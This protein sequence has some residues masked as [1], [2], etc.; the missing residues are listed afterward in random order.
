MQRL[1][2]HRVVIGVGAE[3]V[4]VKPVA[5]PTASLTPFP[6]PSAT[7]REARQGEGGWGG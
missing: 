7:H 4:L 3:R 6:S 5:L 1:Q 2:Q